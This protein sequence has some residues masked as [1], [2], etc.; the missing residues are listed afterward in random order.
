MTIRLYAFIL[1]IILITSVSSATLLVNF[2]NPESS[3]TLAFSLMGVSVFLA[4]SSLL[5]FFIFFIKKV[6]YRGDIQL[7]TMN[8]SLRQSILISLGGLAT[9]G[10]YILDIPETRLILM[11]WATVACLEVM[12]QAIE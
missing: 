2:M 10:L 8:A 7:S 9:L 3:M 6:Y 4:S 11:I 12:V 1:L 5:T